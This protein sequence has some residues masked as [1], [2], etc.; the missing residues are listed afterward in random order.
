V[1]GH[2]N[3]PTRFL[4][5]L[6]LP[7]ALF[8]SLVPLWSAGGMVQWAMPGWL[9][10]LPLAGKYLADQA[11]NTRWPYRWAVASGAMFLLF[12]VLACA[13]VQTGWLGQEFPR[14]FRKGDPTADTVEWWPLGRIRNLGDSAGIAKTFV[15]TFN[16]RDAAKIDQVLGDQM[17]VVVASDDP[18][19]F[20]FAE[21]AVSLQGRTAL[22]VSRSARSRSVFSD[23]GRCF[24]E[25]HPLRQIEIRRGAS[26]VASLTVTRGI[27]YRPSQCE[28]W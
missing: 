3:E 11:T 2:R 23:V 27:S 21:D 1:W 24:G 4:L 22:I 16:W 18:R 8:F 25:I 10:L 5:W 26:V 20:A 7:A 28:K 6:G 17:P 19:D 15:L 13:E 14:L 12:V 9:M